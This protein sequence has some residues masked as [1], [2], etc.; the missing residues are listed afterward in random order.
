MLRLAVTV[1]FAL[2]A[3]L[4]TL[5]L[6]LLQPQGD[7]GAG[8]ATVS[9]WLS[10]GGATVMYAALSGLVVDAIRLLFDLR[11]GSQGTIGP[12]NIGTLNGRAI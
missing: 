11:L 2:G 8:V 3:V 1:A 4:V 5:A 12:R 7:S 9:D 10:L 6:C